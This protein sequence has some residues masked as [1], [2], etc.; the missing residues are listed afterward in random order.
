[1]YG[2]LIEKQKAFFSTRQTFSVAYRKEKLQLLKKLIQQ[3][4]KELMQA[5]RQDLGKSDFEAY[6]T[7]IGIVLAEINLHLKKLRYWA[8]PRPVG[9]PLAAIP[10]MSRIQ[11]EPLGTVLILSPWNYPFQLALA[12]LLGAISAGN[13]A[14]L[15]PSEF[16]PH[17]SFLIS[18]MINDHFDPA[19]VHVITGDAQTS[20]ALTQQA[21]DLI[22]FTGSTQTGRL[23]AKAAADKLIPVVL[24]LGG[25]SPCIVHDDAHIK[26]AARR[27]IWGKCLNAGQTCIAPDYILVSKKVKEKLISEMKK[28]IHVFF[29]SDISKSP[30]YG[31]IIS[32]KHFDRLT[33]LLKHGNLIHGGH[34]DRDT[35]FLAPALIDHV[36]PQ[37]QLMQEEIFGPILPVLDY[38]N[39][40]DAF[41]FVNERPK[42]LAAY[43]FSGKRKNRTA[44]LHS[45]SAGGVTLNDTIMHFT[46]HA[47]PFG[48]VGQSGTGRYHGY[49]SFR[50]F[51][52]TKAVMKRA[53]WIDIP[54]RYAPFGQKLKFVKKLLS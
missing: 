4:E 44:F 49:E 28:A 27:I 34:A 40:E 33:A 8:R 48:G 13:C 22:F 20:S 38:E 46:N 37:S 35:L 3:H 41:A 7:E 15:K 39:L 30:D 50:V 25:K 36:D 47:L 31:R 43:F 10:A 18:K 54:V 17:T 2:E 51:S 6:A 1:M 29:G 45:V 21:F 26:Q 23:V 16:S 24:E 9:T 32:E 5:L 11:Y 19:Y 52:N 12:P 53:T 42:P 14:V